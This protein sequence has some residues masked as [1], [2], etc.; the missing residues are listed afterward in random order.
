MDS[1]NSF[2]V[3]TTITYKID[4]LGSESG[5]IFSCCKEAS[6]STVGFRFFRVSGCDNRLWIS[7]RLM[8]LAA[9]PPCFPR[10][11]SHRQ[12]A[13]YNVPCWSRADNFSSRRTR[14]EISPESPLGL[15]T[16][17]MADEEIGCN[18]L[19]RK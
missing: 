5:D 2:R 16:F 14:H 12:G 13:A 11:R 1:D 9:P 15:L 10:P 6:R 8:D 17:E 18:N 3:G 19:Q 4:L 7:T